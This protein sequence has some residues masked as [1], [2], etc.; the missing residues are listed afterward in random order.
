MTKNIKYRKRNMIL[1][2]KY[3]VTDYNIDAKKCLSYL[4]IFGPLS[5]MTHRFEDIFN[6]RKDLRFQWQQTKFTFM[7][8]SCSA[9]NSYRTVLGDL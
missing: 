4:P 9:I 8:I 6:G 2:I 3:R 1:S 5:S 7:V